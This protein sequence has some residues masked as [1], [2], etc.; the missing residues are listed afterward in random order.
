MS[1]VTF[2]CIVVMF[3]LVGRNRRDFRPCVHLVLVAMWARV[4]VVWM[5]L[6]WRSN[7]VNH[8]DVRYSLMFHSALPR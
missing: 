6:D 3:S 5:G 4:C 2:F 8:S 1:I 7:L